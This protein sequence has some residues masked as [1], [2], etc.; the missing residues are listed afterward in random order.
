ML[1]DA[2]GPVVVV[3]DWAKAVPGQIARWV[4]GKYTSPGT[5]GWVLFGTGPERSRGL[6]A[7]ATARSQLDLP[8]SE[9]L[10]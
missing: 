9:A 4:P 10:S 6:P 7:Q 2:G 1:A 5:D 8:V 3:P